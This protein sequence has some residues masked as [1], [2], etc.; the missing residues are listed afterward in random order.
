MSKFKV[1][2][3]GIGDAFSAFHYSSCLALH[4]DS[5][6]WL[7][8]CPHPIRKIVRE[9]ATKASLSLDLDEF[10]GILLS[11]L[12]ADHSSGVESYAY[13]M[14]Y[15]VQRGRGVLYAHPEVSKKLWPG[16]L[17]GSMEWSVHPG[18]GPKRRDLSDFL[19]LKDLSENHPVQVGPFSVECRFTGH[20]IPTTAFRITACGRTLGC[21]ADATFDPHLISWLDEA[22]LIIHEAGFGPT[23]TPYDKLHALPKATREKMRLI[24]CPDDFDVGKSVISALREGEYFEV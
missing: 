6:W 24:H 10:S 16:K 20:S 4:A 14:Q 5:S 22:D 23:H 21:S 19:E 7:L 8:D 13:Y 9:A 17:A 2:V 3:L 1:L 11:H 18:Q 15:V 12:H